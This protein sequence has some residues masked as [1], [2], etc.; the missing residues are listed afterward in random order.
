MGREQPWDRGEWWCML[1]PAGQRA[2]LVH[3]LPLFKW[4]QPKESPQP[5]FKEK[6]P[7]AHLC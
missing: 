1:L 7:V 3:G 6:L 5:K 2:R 4:G